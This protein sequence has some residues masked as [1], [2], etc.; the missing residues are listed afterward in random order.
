MARRSTKPATAIGADVAVRGEVVDG[1]PA[2]AAE[3]A[4][5]EALR[6]GKTALWKL[7]EALWHFDQAEGWRVVGKGSLSQWLED[8]SIDMTRGTYY[9]LVR[10][11]QKL[12]IEKGLKREQLDGVDMSKAALVADNIIDGEVRPSTALRDVRTLPA[13][14]L[15]EKY[16]KAPRGRPA[17]G[18]E[19]GHAPVTALRA[20]RDLPWDWIEQ[21]VRGHAPLQLREARLR[22][23]LGALLAWRDEFLSTAV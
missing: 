20:A 15:R 3:Q 12:A 9:R 14:K 19:T 6:E 18:Q 11:W 23:A 16:G 22:E 5:R 10:T 1:S 17:K 8:P 4:V 7:A 2:L 21:A 13:S